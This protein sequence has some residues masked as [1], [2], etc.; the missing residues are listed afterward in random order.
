[1]YFTYPDHISMLNNIT[2]KYFSKNNGN[3]SK[4]SVLH[5]NNNKKF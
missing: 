2:V 1:M 5:N 3:Y 4:Q